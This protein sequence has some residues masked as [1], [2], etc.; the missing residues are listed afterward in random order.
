MTDVTVMLHDRCAMRMHT[1]ALPL[2]ANMEQLQDMV[3]EHTGLPRNSQV[4]R[5]SVVEDVPTGL[6]VTLY[7]A[8]FTC[9][10]KLYSVYMLAREDGPT[11]CIFVRVLA[12]LKTLEVYDWYT[13]RQIKDIMHKECHYPR[14]GMRLC[15]AGCFLNDDDRIVDCRIRKD[16]MVDLLWS[17]RGGMMHAT[18]R[19]C[20]SPCDCD[21]CCA[22]YLKTSWHVLIICACVFAVWTR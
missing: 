22:H 11:Y 12:K 14:E 1:L 2:G 15:Y 13:V 4:L 19:L 5:K 16:S 21:W 7:D 18:V 3:L 20:H 17:L 10:T 6:G 9:A 8:G